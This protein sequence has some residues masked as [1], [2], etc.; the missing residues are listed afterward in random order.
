MPR[1]SCA[2]SGWTPD[3]DRLNRTRVSHVLCQRSRS[4]GMNRM[5]AVSG[6]G[7]QGK[8]VAGMLEPEVGFE[9]SEMRAVEWSPQGCG[10]LHARRAAGLEVVA[11]IADEDGFA[12]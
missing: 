3:S 10:S 11:R 2:D 9:V 12:R 7:C 1:S 6:I 8:E 5:K 4:K